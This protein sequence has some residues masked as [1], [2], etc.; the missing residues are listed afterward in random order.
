MLEERLAANPS[1]GQA[2]VTSFPD[3]GRSQDRG[4]ARSRSRDRREMDRFCEIRSR[5]ERG[6][7]E[8]RRRRKGRRPTRVIRCRAEEEE[9]RVVGEE[10][11]DLSVAREKRESSTS[12]GEGNGLVRLVIPDSDSGGGASGAPPGYT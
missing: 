2:G 9:V 10:A 12:R 7:R 3:R 5:L 6:E 11:I 4:E 1:L 8:D